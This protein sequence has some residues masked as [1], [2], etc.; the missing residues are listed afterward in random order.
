[1]SLHDLK[2][3]LRSVAFHA[4]PN[5]PGQVIYLETALAILDRHSE[6]MKQSRIVLSIDAQPALADIA[7]MLKDLEKKE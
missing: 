6:L 7:K 3:D 5:H 2:T 4:G 1:M